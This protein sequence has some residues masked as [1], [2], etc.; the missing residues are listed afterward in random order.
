LQEALDGRKRSSA[1]QTRKKYNPDFPLRQFLL[2]PHCDERVRGSRGRSKTGRYYHYYHC[3]SKECDFNARA[4]NVHDAFENFLG[5]LEPSPEIL[6]LFREIVVDKWV[7]KYQGVYD[8]V[9]HQKQRVD[10]LAEE[11]RKLIQLMKDS[12]DDPDLLAG[13]R[14]E[15]KQVTAKHNAA[16]TERGGKETLELDAGEVVDYCMHF[17]QHASK[18]W[19][20]ASVEQKF[21]LQ[22]LIFPEGIGYDAL[23][24]KQTPQLSPVYQVIEGLKTSDNTLA[25]P[26]GIEPRLTD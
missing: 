13:L 21:Q 14:A 7:Q 8:E 17:L 19:Q 4:E 10:K 2:C 26:R 22:L 12:A 5:K 18:L 23:T 16:K 24:G 9:K 1:V 15:F 25:A 3:R 20:K 6:R 11:K